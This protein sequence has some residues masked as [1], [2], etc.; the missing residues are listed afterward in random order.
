MSDLR[1]FPQ[2]A[3]ESELEHLLSE[4]TPAVISS[5]KNLGPSPGQQDEIDRVYAA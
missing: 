4:P 5:L 3:D 1:T 2:V